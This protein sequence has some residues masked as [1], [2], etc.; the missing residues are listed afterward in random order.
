MQ[1]LYQVH[2]SHEKLDCTQFMS[3]VARVLL[4]GCDCVNIDT[5]RLKMALLPGQETSDVSILLKDIE[6][7][8]NDIKKAARTVSVY[9]SKRRP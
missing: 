5:L 8:N 3:D 9:V 4:A 1:T 6:T 7:Q 2:L